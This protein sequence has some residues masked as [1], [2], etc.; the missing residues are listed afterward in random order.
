MLSHVALA[1]G[2]NCPPEPTQGT[3]IADGQI[4]IGTNCTLTSPGDV[5]GFVFSGNSGETYHIVLAVNGAF[6]TNICMNIYDPN[7]HSI[8]SGCTGGPNQPA[9]LVNQALTVTG[10]YTIDITEESTATISYA[11]SLERLYP[12]PPNAQQI[13]LDTQYPGD[14]TPITDSNAFTFQ[15]VTTG[16]F[17]VS[18]TV[19]GAF[20]NNVCM[21]VYFQDGTHIG[22][23][24]CTS[25]PQHPTITIDFTPTENGTFMAFFQ[26]LENDGTQTYTMEVSCLVGECGTS[27]IPA[28]SGYAIFQGVPLAGAGVTLIQTG[29]P[30]QLTTTNSIGYYQFGHVVS[31]EGYNVMIHGQGDPGAPGLGDA[32]PANTADRDPSH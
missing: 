11:L 13:S 12:F 26:V 25:G 31:G 27:P 22:T 19:T 17:Q 9:V 16:M 29:Q 24:Q 8:F 5:D 23:E 20:N 30:L 21:D 28:V 4:Y 14:I 1:Q 2:T 18:A 7:L 3:F 15:A 6:P 10:T 32:K